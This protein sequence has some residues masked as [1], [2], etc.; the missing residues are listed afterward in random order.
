MTALFIAFSSYGQEDEVIT[1]KIYVNFIPPEPVEVTWLYPSTK[2]TI[3]FHEEIQLRIGIN[4]NA[5]IE[6]LSLLLNG[7]PTATSL[8]DIKLVQKSHPDFDIYI[9]TKAILNE[10]GN[11]LKFVSSSVNDDIGSSERTLVMVNSDKLA[12]ENRNDYAL[13]FATDEYDEWTDLRN[14]IND[15]RTIAKELA[16]NYDF[17]VEIVENYNQDEVLIKIKEYASREYNKYD[18]LFIFFAGHGQ[19][20]ELLAQGYIVSKDSKKDDAAKSTYIPHGVLRS[21]INNIPSDHVLLVMDVCYGGSFDPSITDGSSRGERDIY[22][23]IDLNE[24]IER[25]LKFKTRKY[26]TSGGLQYVPD[27]RPGMHSPFASKVLEGLRSYGGKDNVLTLPELNSWLDRIDPE[28]RS[29]SFGNDE[30]GSDFIFI[31]KE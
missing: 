19:F 21:A 5:E 10:G 18:Q 15:A 23:E 1:E 24:F 26:I 4:S 11:I 29:G 22:S 25:R 27:G 6:K 14:P 7:I 30:P 2:D 3:V 8:D 31:V 16:D 9:E 20:D 28:P 13:L 17:K 12:I